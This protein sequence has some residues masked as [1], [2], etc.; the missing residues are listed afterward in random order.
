M[1]PWN[2][3]MVIVLFT[4]LSLTAVKKRRQTLGPRSVRSSSQDT[5]YTRVKGRMQLPILKSVKTRLFLQFT[6]WFQ[7]LKCCISKYE[8]LWNIEF[9]F[10]CYIY[11]WNANNLMRMKVSPLN[12]FPRTRARVCVCMG[13]LQA[14]SGLSK[15]TILLSYSRVRSSLRVGKLYYLSPVSFKHG[16]V[17][18]GIKSYPRSKF[19]NHISNYPKSWWINYNNFYV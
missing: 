8:V 14:I 19:K 9:N 18:R 5:V 13:D 16:K 12:F 3:V 15:T 4:T 2:F 11:I 17:A 7:Y 1:S 6:L 10:T